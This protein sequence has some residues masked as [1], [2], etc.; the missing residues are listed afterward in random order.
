M[1]A[2]DR[3][4]ISV[5]LIDAHSDT[6]IW[7]DSFDRDLS[8]V[9]VLQSEVARAVAKQIQL[10]LTP[11]EVAGF[12]DRPVVDPEAHDAYLRGMLHLAETNP[13][14]ALQAIEYFERAIERDPEYALAYG[15]MARAYVL[16]SWLFD[17]LPAKEVMP[18]ARVAAEKALVLDQS[19]G[20]AHSTLGAVRWVYDWEWEQGAAQLRQAVELS[21]NDPWALQAYG[22]YL[23]ALGRLDDALP[24]GYWVNRSRFR[25]LSLFWLKK[26]K[27]WF[28]TPPVPSS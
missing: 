8:N 13:P 12:E 16:L 3:V 28:P 15:G 17:Y 11:Q 6:H 22:W 14:D 25:K 18:K 2:A 5:Q 23:L 1:R 27:N 19:L 4:R 7:N 20:L 24:P 26:F 9:L 10:E 21:P